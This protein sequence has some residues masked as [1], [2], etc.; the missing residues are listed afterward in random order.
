M[1]S[2]LSGLFA[3]TFFTVFFTH[4]SDIPIPI[5]YAIFLLLAVGATLIAVILFTAIYETARQLERFEDYKAEFEQRWGSVD[6]KH[7]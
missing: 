1:A 4:V 2:V 3:T 7:S 6:N 5:D